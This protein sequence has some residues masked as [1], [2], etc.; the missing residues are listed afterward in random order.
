MS[1]EFHAA[2]SSSI[3]QR[4]RIHSSL[5]QPM[6]MNDNRKPIDKDRRVAS[7]DSKRAEDRFD[8]D[9]KF[10][11]VAPKA[12]SI[13]TILL[14]REPKELG[15]G[16]IKQYHYDSTL[17]Q[18]TNK[19]WAVN[20]SAQATLPSSKVNPRRSLFLSSNPFEVQPTTGSS[21]N[22]TQPRSPMSIVSPYPYDTLS[23]PTTPTDCIDTSYR[24]T[25]PPCYP[26]REMTYDDGP[27]EHT[28]IPE[29]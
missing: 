14:P 29:L 17:Q 19:E 5:Q 21:S 8:V 1:C 2:C 13:R 10:V 7:A 23:T 6:T 4:W 16:S 26:R 24:S 28:W 18:P 12:N 22:A 27:P 15:E 11:L 25:P 9:S 3:S 20:D